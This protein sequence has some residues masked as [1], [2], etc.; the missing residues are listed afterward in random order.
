M[1]SF[2]ED[3]FRTMTQGELYN[4]SVFSASRFL[5]NNLGTMRPEGINIVYVYFTLATLAFKFE[6]YKT[7][8]K[9]FEKL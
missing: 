8:R 2:L 7:A 9:G 4:E 1:S 3:S 5:V 6:A